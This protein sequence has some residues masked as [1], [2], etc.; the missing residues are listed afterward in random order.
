MERQE[1]CSATKMRPTATGEV[2]VKC[3]KALGHVEAGD[4]DH[5][6]MTGPFPL[7]WRDERG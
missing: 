4:P 5:R 1:K 7:V 2:E 3:T 6:G